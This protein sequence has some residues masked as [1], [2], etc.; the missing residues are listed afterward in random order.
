MMC[1]NQNQYMEYLIEE[2]SDMV[3][4]L[5]M[6][7][8]RNKEASEDVYQEVFF[9]IAKK[10]PEFADKE[11][12]KAWLIRV[13]INCSKNILGDKFM[14]HNVAEINASCQDDETFPDRNDEK[15][16]L[17][18]AVLEL[19]LK[20]RTVIYLFYYEG[21]KIEEI[22]KILKLNENT[23]KAQ[24]SRARQKLKEKMYCLD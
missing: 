8:T 3:Y 19:P 2:Y 9:R 12:E 24:L 4:R 20:D 11:H 10:R 1:T 18:Y 15:N 7:R 21:Y 16:D 23:V 5:A 22:S 6:S 13:T 14:K 17:Y